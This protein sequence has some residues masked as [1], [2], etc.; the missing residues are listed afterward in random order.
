VTGSAPAP[1]A[2]QQKATEYVANTLIAFTPK[3]EDVE[4]PPVDR[5][6]PVENCSAETLK[7]LLKAKLIREAGTPHP[8]DV[9]DDGEADA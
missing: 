7:K 4:A 5:D 1:A 9:E 3:G 6:E 8:D 2:K